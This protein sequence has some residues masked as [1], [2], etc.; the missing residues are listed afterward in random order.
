MNQKKKEKNIMPEAIRMT[1][2]EAIKEQHEH[3]SACGQSMDACMK[4]M[5]RVVQNYDKVRHTWPKY[6]KGR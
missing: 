1:I 3:C 4:C 6:L 2:P 5:Y